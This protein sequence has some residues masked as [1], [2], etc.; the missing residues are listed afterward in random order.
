MPDFYKYPVIFV[1][2]VKPKK[3]CSYWTD[4]KRLLVEAFLSGYVLTS[5]FSVCRNLSPRQGVTAN[6][7]SGGGGPGGGGGGTLTRRNANKKMIIPPDHS[8][9]RMNI[10]H[11]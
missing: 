2:G 9:L 8:E 10:R 1:E 7:E 4:S 6:E 5:F 3:I 11:S